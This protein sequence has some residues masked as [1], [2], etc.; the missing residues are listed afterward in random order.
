MG[1][2][3]AEPCP[4]DGDNSV[5]CG[6]RSQRLRF[7]D[8]LAEPFSIAAP[9]QKIIKLAGATTH[10]RPQPAFVASF[11]HKTPGFIEFEHM[12]KLPP[13][14]TLLLNSTLKGGVCGRAGTSVD[15]RGGNA[16]TCSPIHRAMVR[17]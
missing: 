2:M 16:A 12:T 8:F 1:G 17:R 15:M 3:Q 7:E 10:D 5:R 4:I 13:C 11:A 6:P 14:N 9:I